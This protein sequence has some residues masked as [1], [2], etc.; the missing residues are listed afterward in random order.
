MLLTT[1]ALAIVAC[2]EAPS[3]VRF[4]APTAPRAML[5]LE[6]P[7][8]GVG[9]VATLELAVVTPAGHTPR[10]V[11]PPAEL[12]GLW[13]LDQEAL[14]IEKQGA[15][16][17]HR[18]RFRLRAHAVGAFTW[19]ASRIELEAPDGTLV[20]LPL[21][22]LPIE[23]ISVLPEYPDRLGPFGIRPPPPA[24]AGDAFWGP[25]AAGALAALAGVGLVALA[26]RRRRVLARTTVTPAPPPAAPAWQR[27]GED[28]ERAR[29]L[30]GSD[31]FAAAHALSRSLCRYMARR[32]G[33]EAVGRTSPE[34]AAATPP[35]A[36]TSCW[37]V[38]VALL[39]H[40]DELRFRPE[41]DRA[42]RGALGA[43]LA[44]LLT[45]A[46]A[47]IADTTPPEARR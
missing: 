38:F 34:L 6:P 19:P 39:S 36:A 33:A 23:V 13:I 30:A 21:D 43:R 5:V 2:S 20:D 14:P 8:I 37:P 27:A 17:V 11:A 42:A 9:Q 41:T 7:R 16:W 15:R 47:F 40:L 31:P 32:F 28:L 26:R 45:E 1:V 12:S 25:A 4:A 35:F 10:P 29:E 24:E 18:I 22:E 3:Q 46:E 44:G